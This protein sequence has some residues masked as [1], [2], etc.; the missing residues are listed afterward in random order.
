[1]GLNVAMWFFFL[2]ETITRMWAWGFFNYFEDK[3]NIADFITVV[4]LTVPTFVELVS[5]TKKVESIFDRVFVGAV[6]W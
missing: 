3:F 6:C 1:M 2:V 4:L 5:D